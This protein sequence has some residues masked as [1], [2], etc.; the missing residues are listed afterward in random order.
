VRCQRHWSHAAR[1]G[2]GAAGAGLVQLSALFAVAPGVGASTDDS[3]QGCKMF[4]HRSSDPHVRG[5][6]LRPSFERRRNVRSGRNPGPVWLP[7]ER[8]ARTGPWIVPR[9]RS[10]KTACPGI[11]LRPLSANHGQSRALETCTEADDER[12]A[13]C[14]ISAAP[15]ARSDRP[16]P[17]WN[18][19]T[20]V[21]IVP[22]TG[23][24]YERSLLQLPTPT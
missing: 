17:G 16:H 13:E 22:A 12:D 1:A 15:E 20:S 14:K 18:R 6:R 7:D 23:I 11:F 4:H 5:R 19:A 3:K 24:D 10:L 2:A 9:R 21:D 8:G